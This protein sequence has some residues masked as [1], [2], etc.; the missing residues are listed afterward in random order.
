MLPA[1]VFC[2]L[3][4]STALAGPP[5]IVMQR[6]ADPVLEG[7]DITLECLSDEDEDMSGYVFQKYSKWMQSW[8]QLD[9]PNTFR[10]WYYDVNVTREEGRLM[11]N[12]KDVQS[13]QTGPYRCISVNASSTNASTS[14]SFTIPIYYL[15]DIFLSQ[16]NSW[17]GTVDD[18]LIVQEGSNVEIRCSAQSSQ[19]PIY[20]W[21]REGEDWIKVSDT[22]KLVKVLKEQSG[23]YTC[24]AREPRRVQSS[25]EEV[26]A[27]RSDYSNLFQNSMNYK[28][29]HSLGPSF[30]PP[31]A[32]SQFSMSIP[33]LVMAIAV[34]AL[35]LLVVSLI[36]GIFIKR[37]RKSHIEKKMPLEESGQRSPIYRG[38]LE[39]VPSMVGDTQPLVI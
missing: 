19:T 26:C 32:L 10:C 20:E 34:P 3:F 39:S 17:C 14:A 36:I 16:I 35:A 28:S 15:R 2:L 9:Q 31:G 13:W 1:F 5:T 27:A 23:T 6:S 4:L 18:P 30:S 24:Q 33:H 12:V 8:V 7:S 25:E 29:M 38:S 11:L 21:N 22:L 37:H